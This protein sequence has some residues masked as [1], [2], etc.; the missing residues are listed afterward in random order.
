MKEILKSCLN[1]LGVGISKVSPEHEI[2]TLDK[3]EK[4][5]Y[6][7]NFGI[8]DTSIGSKNLGDFIIM[9]SIQAQLFE[10]FNDSA[11]FTTFPT[12]FRVTGDDRNLLQE[13]ELLFVCGTNLLNS[14][15]DRNIQWNLWKQDWNFYHKRC[16]LVGTGWGKYDAP[17]SEGTKEMLKRILSDK[18]LHSVRDQYSKEMLNSIG[19]DNVV[20]TCC[21]TS[22][23]IEVD[24]SN[25]N[26]KKYVVSTITDYSQDSVKDGW[27][28]K[29][30]L[31]NYEYVHIWIQSINDLKYLEKLGLLKHPKLRLISPSLE[32][33][34]KFLDSNVLDI[35]YI[36]T[37]LHAGIYAMQRNIRTLIIGI[38]NRANEIAKD[39]KINVVKREN[40]EDIQ[41][42]VKGGI[43]NSLELPIESIFQWKNSFNQF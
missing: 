13:K 8:L 24:A 23:K 39:V 36:G 9:D 7:K 32:A 41:G 1:R 38:D 17:P 10:L 26:K 25:Q 37:R 16:V 15:M 28:L 14:N 43:P 3:M 12:H 22:W 11:Y 35:D 5:K 6:F 2:S 21:P 42:F 33:Y 4:N 40:I 31:T 27:M 30:L 19:I 34:R 18:V 29:Y 20:N